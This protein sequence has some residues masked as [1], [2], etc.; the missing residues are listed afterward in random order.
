M[1]RL[2]Q[3]IGFARKAPRALDMFL[4]SFFLV[5]VIG[6]I[7]PFFFNKLDRT[8][9]DSSVIADIVIVPLAVLIIKPVLVYI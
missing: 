2:S 4:E 9:R 7:R 8:V 3:H 1:L 6:I 5:A